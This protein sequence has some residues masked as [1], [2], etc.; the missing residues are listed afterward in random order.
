MTLG[1][2]ISSSTTGSQ[3]SSGIVVGLGVGPVLQLTRVGIERQELVEDPV[4]DCQLDDTP[5]CG[6]LPHDIAVLEE[7]VE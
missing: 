4:V 5:A 3:S 1:R 6:I 7:V 2:A